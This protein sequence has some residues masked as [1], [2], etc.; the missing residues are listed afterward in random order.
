MIVLHTVPL[1]PHKKMG[2]NNCI[3]YCP[4][5]SPNHRSCQNI[6]TNRSVVQ[7]LY[8][9]LTHC[10][11]LVHDLIVAEPWGCLHLPQ[12]SDRHRDLYQDFCQKNEG[13]VE[14]KQRQIKMGSRTAY[15]T[16]LKEHL[17]KLGLT[18][19]PTCE[20]CLQE[21]KSATHIL[22]DCEAIAY[23]R[24]RHLGQFFMEPSDFDD[25]PINKTSY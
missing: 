14:I 17:F 19:D 2:F 20:R 18:D 8:M 10:S 12:D 15:W 22:C 4:G 13:P 24:F 3:V 16:L 1:V 5:F 25:V 7:L 21:D 23:L 9:V 6:S 11:Q